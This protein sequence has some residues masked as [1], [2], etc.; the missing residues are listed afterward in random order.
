MVAILGVTPDDAGVQSRNQSQPRQRR[1][2][3]VGPGGVLCREPQVVDDRGA[4]R[5]GT[6]GT[7]AGLIDHRAQ[8]VTRNIL[9]LAYL[10]ERVPDGGFKTNRRAALGDNDIS[11]LH[12]RIHFNRSEI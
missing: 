9:D 5:L 2:D 10:V 6:V 12:L 11:R 8:G 3:A 7:G 1:L 4:D